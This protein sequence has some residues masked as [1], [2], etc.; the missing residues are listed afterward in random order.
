MT[1]REWAEELSG[2]HPI[3]GFSTW[4]ASGVNLED[5]VHCTSLEMYDRKRIQIYGYLPEPDH[6]E[7]NGNLCKV[8]TIWGVEDIYGPLTE[9][10]DTLNR[11]V[12]HA[13][14]KFP[15]FFA[16]GEA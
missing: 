7:R 12:E 14:K 8:Y 9:E 6:C 16:E 13:K 15:E 3:P 4:K 10:F 11:A 1:A 2:N 5:G